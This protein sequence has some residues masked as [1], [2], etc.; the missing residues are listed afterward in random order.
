MNGCCRTCP[1]AETTTTP[2]LRTSG[3]K[4][5]RCPE[6]ETADILVSLGAI[7]LKETQLGKTRRIKAEIQRINE[8]LDA[9]AARGVD[10]TRAS[11]DEMTA[12]EEEGTALMQ[13]L[14][15]CDRDLQFVRK[16]IR[17]H[18]GGGDQ[19]CVVGD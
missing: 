19:K 18:V 8:E 10:H 11:G 9:W 1:R 2:F 6:D 12:Y 13:R 7:I 4:R 14:D 16:M 15:T 5:A 3:R 17:W